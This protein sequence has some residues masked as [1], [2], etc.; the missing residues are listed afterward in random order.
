MW[1][2]TPTN[3]SIGSMRLSLNPIAILLFFLE[4]I[5]PLCALV[6]LS[7]VTLIIHGSSKAHRKPE[8]Y[9]I[10]SAKCCA[11]LGKRYSKYT[12]YHI[13][14]S[15]SLAGRKEY[16][17]GEECCLFL[18]V[19]TNLGE[20][21]KPF[22]LHTAFLPLLFPLFHFDIFYWGVQFNHS[23]HTISWKCDDFFSFITQPL[24]V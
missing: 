16:P 11:S 14:I 12:R 19:S 24:A 5:F 21:E 20:E 4:Y 23:K 9:E 3:S 22:S 6:L 8:I 13:I 10:I 15:L 18:Y 2:Q 17:I 7:K 1:K